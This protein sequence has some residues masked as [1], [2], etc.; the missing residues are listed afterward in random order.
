MTEK[1]TDLQQSKATAGKMID[2]DDYKIKDANDTTLLTSKLDEK[3]WHIT[4]QFTFLLLIT[5]I[6]AIGTGI[7]LGHVEVSSFVL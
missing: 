2:N 3:W 7:I 6:G 1:Q 4:I 5:G